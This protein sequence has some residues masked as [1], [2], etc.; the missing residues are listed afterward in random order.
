LKSTLNTTIKVEECRVDL[1]TDK[2]D[3]IE[4][5]KEFFIELQNRDIKSL[6]A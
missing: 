1:Q 3:K 6:S 4:Q 2:K 5:E